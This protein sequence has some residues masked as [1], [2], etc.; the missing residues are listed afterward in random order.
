MAGWIAPK[1][2][3]SCGR[4]S[5]QSL[6]PDMNLSMVIAIIGAMAIGAIEIHVAEDSP[7]DCAGRHLRLMKISADHANVPR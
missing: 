6:R 4:R 5:A 7:L 3:P 1:S 2:A